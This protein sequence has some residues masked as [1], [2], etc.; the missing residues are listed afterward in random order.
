MLRVLAELP[1]G[2]WQSSHLDD[3]AQVMSEALDAA[4]F[5]HATA[6]AIGQLVF[7]LLPR[8]P[9]WGAKRLVVLAT[10]HGT[11][12][13]YNIE[14]LLSDAD[15]QRLAPS[16]L[17]VLHAWRDRER[18]AEIFAVASAL[19]KRLKVFDG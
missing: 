18:Q 9:D 14:K 12:R 1:P 4:D 3:L 15:V 11:L 5:S 19:G 8:Y 10:K 17:P 16:L 2:S 7:H 13:G 6:R